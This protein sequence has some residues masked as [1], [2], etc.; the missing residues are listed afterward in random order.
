MESTSTF[1]AM[2]R[3]YLDPDAMQGRAG[4]K[5]GVRPNHRIPGAGDQFL[6]GQ[7]DFGDNGLLEPGRWMPATGH[8]IVNS[9]DLPRLQPGFRWEICEG[10]KVIGSAEL[11]KITEIP[12]TAN[13]TVLPALHA[14]KP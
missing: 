10:Q 12:P 11:I 1:K 5:P 4:Y 6:M 2:L 8:F 14:E 9:S 13:S 7:L 3:C